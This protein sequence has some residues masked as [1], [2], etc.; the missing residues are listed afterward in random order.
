MTET[1]LPNPEPTITPETEPMWR[2]AND[3]RL[4]LVRC[5]RCERFLWYPRAL[6]SACSTLDTGWYEAS[7]RGTVYSFTVVRRGRDDYE[8][9]TPYVLAYVELDEGPR[10]MTNI[11]ECE[12][13][14]LAVGLPV[15]VVFHHS[16]S[17]QAFPRFRPRTATPSPASGRQ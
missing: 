16:A 1:A 13:D 11:V 6:C 4:L 8:A 5:N 15:E 12:L 10:V 2:A 7:G 17:G 3:G 9:A 14:D